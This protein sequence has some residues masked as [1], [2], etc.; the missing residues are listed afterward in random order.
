MDLLSHPP[1]TRDFTVGIDVG[2]TSVKAVAVDGDGALLGRARIPHQVH[3]PTPDRLEHDAVSAWLDGPRRALAAA[4]TAAGATPVAV[5]VAALTPTMVPV[6]GDGCPLGPGVL[7]GDA[8]GGRPAGAVEPMAS[9]ETAALLA[10]AA[11]ASPGAAGYWT[12]QAVAN[13]GLGGPGSIDYATAC[14]TGTLFDGSAWD[15]AVAERAGPG[16]SGRLPAVAGFGEAIGEVAQPWCHEPGVVLGAGSVDAF[17]EQLVA[18]ADCAGDVLVICG[19]TLVVWAT[20]EGWPEVPGLWTVPHLRAGHAALGG[21]SNAGG[22]FVDWVDRLVSPASGVADPSSVPVWWPY[23]RGERVPLHDPTRRGALGGLDLTAGPAEVRRA[24]REASGFAVRHILDT[25]G[26]SP[27]RIIVSGG[28]TND[29]AWMQALAD[30]LGVEVTP[31]CAEGAARG[32]A[33]LARMAAGI[34][35][36]VEGASRWSVRGRAVAPDRRWTGPVS[37]RYERYRAGIAEGGAL[38]VR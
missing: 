1:R 3:T 23:V 17:C 15:V 28:G 22:L 5:A 6:D 8:R 9:G 27:R 21:A 24:A 34:E 31:A 25:A 12:A 13:R 36:S 35:G 7:Y 26:V 2:T 38:H 14:S 10:W 19:S 11:S 20:V 16:A 32:A 30:V 18:G 29:P 33:W 37:E 4:V